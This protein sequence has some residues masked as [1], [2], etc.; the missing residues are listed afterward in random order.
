MN[1]VPSIQ[2]KLFKRQPLYYGLTHKIFSTA[3]KTWSFFILIVDSCL[4]DFQIYIMR[5][6]CYFKFIYS[7]KAKKLSI[8]FNLTNESQNNFGDFFNFFD[9]LRIYLLNIEY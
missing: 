9:L 5:Q 2:S 1:L 4:M 8:G 6:V 3:F 7:E